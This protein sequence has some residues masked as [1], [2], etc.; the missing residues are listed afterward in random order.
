MNRIAMLIFLGVFFIGGK[1]F[2][3]GIDVG[4][5]HIHGTHVKV[6]SDTTLKII[7]DKIIMDGDDKD[8]VKKLVGHRK[9][10]SDDKFNI[11]VVL[12]ELDGDSKDLL[13]KIVND[14]VYSMKIEKLD[15]DWKLLRIRK[16]ED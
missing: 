15:D 6:G 4:P 16:S 1:A 9:G 8:L 2:A 13:K 7:I 3:F 11:K 5:V 14:N 12:S 10:D